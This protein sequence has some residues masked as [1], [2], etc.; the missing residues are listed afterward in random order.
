MRYFSS[1]RECASCSTFA[2]GGPEDARTSRFNYEDGFG[3][4]AQF[5]EPYGMILLH[6]DCLQP[7]I[8][9]TE[10]IDPASSIVQRFC[11]FFL[12]GIAVSND[13]RW[14]IVA[15]K[16][17]HRLRKI[18]ISTGEVST[19]AGPTCNVPCAPTCLEGQCCQRDGGRGTCKNTRLEADSQGDSV[20]IGESVRFNKP[21]S[22]AVHP[23]DRNP[24]YAVV[25]DQGNNRIRKTNIDGS[26]PGLTTVR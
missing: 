24:Q 1:E 13:M 21:V 26:Q 14:L 23:S 9:V 12:T 5:A 8:P 19:L 7:V 10:H 17:S 4:N 18:D 16:K 22:V 3:T 25:V 2:G 20:G 6:S 11:M 15:E